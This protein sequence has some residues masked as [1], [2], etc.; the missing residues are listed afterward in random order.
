MRRSWISRKAK[1]AGGFGFFLGGCVNICLVLEGK[2]SDS[3][4]NSLCGQVVCL[5]KRLEV[6][7]N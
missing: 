1:V 7:L 6:S 5:K 4:A 2:A 3:R